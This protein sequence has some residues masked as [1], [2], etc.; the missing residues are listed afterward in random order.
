M[1]KKKKKNETH[2]KR[3]GAFFNKGDK[4]RTGKFLSKKMQRL[5]NYRSSYEYAFL[6]HI[7][8]DDN[9][10]QFIVEP[11]SIPYIDASGLRRHYIPDCLVLYKTGYMELCEIKPS[12]MIKAINVKRKAMAA[13]RYIKDNKLK[14]TYR[15]VTEQQL[16]KMNSAY[17]ELLKD[18]K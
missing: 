15:F 11:F 14:M 5:V 10:V 18:L 8:N 6:T 9:V 16:F 13:I 17:R 2:I 3:N 7:E 4:Y 12:K 1:S